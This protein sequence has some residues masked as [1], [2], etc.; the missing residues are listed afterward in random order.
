[1]ILGTAVQQLD[2]AAKRAILTDGRII[3]FKKALIAT[4]GV[5]AIS[6]SQARTCPACITYEG[7]MTPWRLPRRRHREHAPS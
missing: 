5:R 2:V 4:V 6:Q 7:L 1:L 3:D